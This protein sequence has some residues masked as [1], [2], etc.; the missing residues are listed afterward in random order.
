M[1]PGR[2]G[3]R[4]AGAAAGSPFAQR[5]AECAVATVDVGSIECPR[6]ARAV[7]TKFLALVDAARLPSAAGSGVGCVGV[8]LLLQSRRGCVEAFAEDA[9]ARDG[10]V[11]VAEDAKAFRGW[12][13]GP[14]RRRGGETD[15]S[16]GG[17]RAARN[18]AVVELFDHR[19]LSYYDRRT[20]AVLLRVMRSGFAARL[21]ASRSV[22][23]FSLVLSRRARLVRGAFHLPKR[24]P[25]LARPSQP[26]RPVR[27]PCARPRAPARKAAWFSFLA[28]RTPRT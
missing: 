22:E 17:A 2:R 8:A 21:L 7:R 13:R 23:Q 16:Q 12:P 25:F 15:A 14:M 26:S 20:G 9:K 24:P 27:Q 3:S 10:D 6:W 11:G 5:R 18:V 1:D 4:I 19:Y 28:A